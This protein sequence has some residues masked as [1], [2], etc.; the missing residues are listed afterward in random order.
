MNLSQPLFTQERVQIDI[1][2]DFRSDTPPGKDPDAFSPTLR[3]YH[4]QLWSKPLPSGEVFQLDDVTPKAY[5]HH[6]SNAGELF[7]S[8]DSVIPSFR[9]RRRIADIIAQISSAELDA[10]QALGYT[11]GGMMLFPSNRV[12]GK[13][14]IN[15]ARGLN[16]KI[17]DRFDLT[18]ECIR[19]F[20]HSESSPLYDTLACYMSFFDLFGDFRSYVEFFLLQDLVAPDF[21][22]VRFFSPFD[23]FIT[24]PLPNSVDA[25]RSY[26]RL[27]EEFINARNRRIL[28]AG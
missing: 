17:N 20:Y 25:Y 16:H 27:A 6:S 5:L 11:M 9:H 1:T 2:F 21:A 3:S 19:R 15:G 10:F 18:V 7:L 4:K 28:D 13:P 23:D 8:S 22:A 26:K 12:D 14:T 24:S